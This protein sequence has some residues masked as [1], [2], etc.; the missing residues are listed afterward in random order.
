MHKLGVISIITGKLSPI[1]SEKLP[2]ENVQSEKRA[3][4]RTWSNMSVI[5]RRQKKNTP[6]GTVYKRGQE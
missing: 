6:P 5:F 3:Q 4:D 1:K 2:R